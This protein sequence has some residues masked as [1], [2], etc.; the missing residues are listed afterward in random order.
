M[1]RGHSLN[2]ASGQEVATQLN[3][4]LKLARRESIQV[5]SPDELMAGESDEIIA[6]LQ[7]HG[8]ELLH[9]TPLWFYILKEADQRGSGEHL[10]PLGSRLVMETIHGVIDCGDGISI[11]NR[12][13]P[14][15]PTLPKVDRGTKGCFTMVDLLAF[16]GDL[17]PSRL[18]CLPLPREF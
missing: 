6:A 8:A 3:A 10:G 18:H 12:P 1:A 4:D 9:A 14:W 16:M 15:V 7:A 11:L 17:N 2:L 13:S 5:L